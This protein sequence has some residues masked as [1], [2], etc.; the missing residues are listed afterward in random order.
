MIVPLGWIGQSVPHVASPLLWALLLGAAALW[1]RLSPTPRPV[2]FAAG[3]LGL[4]AVPLL[5]VALPRLGA[6]MEQAVFW[7]LAGVTL[8]SAGIAVSSRSPMYMAVWFALSLLGTAGLF[9]FQGAQFLGVATI[10]VYAGAIVVIFLFVLMLAQPQGLTAYDRA[11]WAWFAAPLAVIGGAVWVGLLSLSTSDVTWAAN[12]E[13]GDVPSVAADQDHMARFGAELFARH[14]VS[15]EI[16]G[17]LLLAALVG[18]IAIVI[19]GRQAP[20]P[21]QNHSAVERDERARESEHA[22]E[23]ARE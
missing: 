17:T 9:L 16:A 18:A 8:I 15:V 7:F 1:L 19:H 2:R 11:S 13:A 20:T 3:L 10:V 21:T 23:R 5:F 6:P 4:L 22:Q 12:L 14:L